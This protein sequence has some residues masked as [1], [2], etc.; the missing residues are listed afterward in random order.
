MCLESSFGLGSLPGG[1]HLSLF[2]RQRGGSGLG[3][4]LGGDLETK[5]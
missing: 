4:L 5:R 3:L 2:G 1:G